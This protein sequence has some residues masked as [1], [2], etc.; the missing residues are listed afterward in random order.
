MLKTS[1]APEAETIRLQF[2]VGLRDSEPQLKLPEA[3]RAN[4]TLTVEELLQVIH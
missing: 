3:L 1:T 2:A 4:D